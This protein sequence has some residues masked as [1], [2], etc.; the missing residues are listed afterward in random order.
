MIRNQGYDPKSVNSDQIQLD[1]V[2]NTF[3]VQSEQIPYLFTRM[4]VTHLEEWEEL[5]V[6][7][8]FQTL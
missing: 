1:S 6:K 4:L 3:W 8:A 5:R 7:G 2:S